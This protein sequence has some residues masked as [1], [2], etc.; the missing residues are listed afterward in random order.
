MALGWA[1][2]SEGTCTLDAECPYSLQCWQIENEIYPD[3]QQPE[4]R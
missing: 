2:E 1:C 3:I 4:Q